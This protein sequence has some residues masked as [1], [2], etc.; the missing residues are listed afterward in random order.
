MFRSQTG[1][2]QRGHRKMV[3]GYVVNYSAS[4]HH[5]LLDGD[6]FLEKIT[7]VQKNLKLFTTD[8]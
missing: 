5:N 4:M 1:T 7:L 6:D 3:I 8:R 2:E